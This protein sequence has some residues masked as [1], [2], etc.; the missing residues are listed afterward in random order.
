VFDGLVGQISIKGRLS[1]QLLGGSQKHAYL[2]SGARGMGK[3]LFAKAFAMALLCER[4]AP[5][6]E[7]GHVVA[8]A[9]A[10]GAGD[11][12]SAAFAPDG[13]VP[14]LIPDGPDRRPAHAGGDCPCR[15]CAPCK[16]FSS[17][18]LDDF[19]FVDPKGRHVSVDEIR[20]IVEW[21]SVRPMISARKAYV[22]ADADKMT[23][24]A[25][26]A[27]LKTLEE[28][29]PYVAAILTSSKPESLLDTVRSRCEA[30]RFAKYADSE[31]ADILARR[32][33]SGGAPGFERAAAA[34]AA[35]R[36]ALGGRPNARALQE[37]AAAPGYAG[38]LAYLAKLADGAPGAAIELMLSAQFPEL[39]ERVAGLLGDHLLGKPEALFFIT[40]LLEKQR[41]EMPK[42]VGVINGILRDIWIYAAA[43]DESM[44]VNI[45]KMDIIA[46]AQAQPPDMLGLLDCIEELDALRA[47]AE[48]S[49]NYTLAVNM[50][51]LRLGKLRDIR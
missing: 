20:Q 22:I 3:R 49:A 23:E 48:A 50:M 26:N 21:S 37:T 5:G 18:A 34:W 6:G 42:I 35:A 32:A 41:N 27:L 24:Q 33:G 39:R 30:I 12:R 29:P 19:L 46:S 47:S 25:Q 51:A 45:D 44:L 43:G 2:F 28:P 9:F 7:R 10:A 4:G 17:G 14:S 11:A 13:A 15:E 40:E 36:A 8:R 1:S 16:L 31:I 38:Y